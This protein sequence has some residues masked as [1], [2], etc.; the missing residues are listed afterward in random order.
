MTKQEYLNRLYSGLSGYSY[1]FRRDIIEAFEGHFDEGAA[2]GKSEEEVI[3]ELGPVSDVIDN[4]R[5][6]NGDQGS[7]KTANDSMN[8]MWKSFDQLAGTLKDTLKSVGGIVSE[9]V[10]TAVREIRDVQYTTGSANGVSGSFTDCNALLITMEMCSADIRLIAGPELR[11]SFAPSSSLFSSRI[12]EL[13]TH[14]D[15]GTAG[16]I[17]RNG[18]GKLN[19]TVPS[20][21][22]SIRMGALSGDVSIIGIKTD[23]VI[24]KASSGNIVLDNAAAN[25]F[26]L[27]T[28]SGDLDADH[29]YFSSLRFQT[30]SGDANLKY[31]NGNPFIKT[32]SGDIDIRYHESKQI[33]AEAASGDIDIECTCSSISAATLSG[34]IDINTDAPVS[35]VSAESKSGDIICILHDENYTAEMSTVSGSIENRTG[36]PELRQSKRSLRVGMGSGRV[37]LYTKSGDIELR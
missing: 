1:E 20:G 35:M 32:V 26:T 18:G 24:I 27:Q 37:E 4:I 31:T 28:S 29:T 30:K 14:S 10:N 17:L 2:Q 22:K 25:E 21:V 13:L 12:P 5:M 9:G 23:E 8:D 33:L 16:L 11:Y 7:T 15:N 34:D 19:I 36:I 6:M 3:D